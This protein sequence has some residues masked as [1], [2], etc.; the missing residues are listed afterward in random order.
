[1]KRKPRGK[2]D[3]I[4]RQIEVT[5]RPGEFIHDRACISFGSGLEKKKNASNTRTGG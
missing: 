4:E 3:P 2:V 1:M 5:L